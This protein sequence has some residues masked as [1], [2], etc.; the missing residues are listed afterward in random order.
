[1]HISIA[2]DIKKRFHAA[3]AIRGLKISQVITELVEQWLKANEVTSLSDAK[4]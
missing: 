1:M 3:Y 2:D 4:A